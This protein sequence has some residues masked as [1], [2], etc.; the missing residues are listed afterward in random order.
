LPIVRTMIADRAAAFVGT[1]TREVAI[2]DPPAL[3]VGAWM[4]TFPW[5]IQGFTTR[6]A[7][8]T[9]PFDL[10]LFSGASLAGHVLEH[11]EQL[12]ESTAQPQVVH[13]RQI[14]GA[15]V[16]FHQSGPP[17]LHLV[18]PC[19]G[20][21][22]AVP[23]IV[24]C[25]TTADC[26]PVYVVDPEHPA[27]A[28]LHAG[29]RGAAGGVLERGISVLRERVGTDVTRLHLHLGPAICAHCY[30]VGPEVFEALQQ[31]VPA[32]PMPI[33]LRAILARRAIDV[34]VLPG[35]VTVSR[36]CT[37]CTDSGLFSHRGGDRERQVA[38]IGIRA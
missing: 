12:R 6:G 35:Q 18:E 7:G 2:D 31:P 19:D 27:V 36:H 13:A 24:L 15:R 3:V 5:A 30:E 22:T 26:V 25:V 33:D 17:G 4:T 34:G 32:K 11:W 9:H 20:H 16:R 38:Y 21:A 29:W 14:H 8:F 28:V 10:G 1:S 37:R 23:G